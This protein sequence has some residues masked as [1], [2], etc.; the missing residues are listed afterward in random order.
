MSSRFMP[1][2]MA[3]SPIW[4]ARRPRR[5]FCRSSRHGRV[6]RR[7]PRRGNVAGTRVLVFDIGGGVFLIRRNPAA[8]AKRDTQPA[9][10]VHLKRTADGSAWEVHT[11][12]PFTNIYVGKRKL[13]WQG[14][15][16]APTRPGG[17]AAP[18]FTLPRE[19]PGAAALPSARG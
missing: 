19:E 9:L 14:E 7:S 16:S 2:P 5:L 15:R 3:A 13:L 4:P 12:G 17:Q 11:A 10:V 6:R 1:R 18:S 8:A